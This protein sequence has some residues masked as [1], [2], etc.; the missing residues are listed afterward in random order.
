MSSS[1][2]YACSCGETRHRSKSSQFQPFQ[3]T[4]RARYEEAQLPRTSQK[5]HDNGRLSEVGRDFWRS[6]CPAPLLKQGHL[7]PVVQNCIQT[8]FESL[9]VWRLQ[10]CSEQPV[11]VLGHCHGEKELPDVSVWARCL[12]SCHRTPLRKACPRP[13]YSLTSGFYLHG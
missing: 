10:N 8:T 7:D 11:P 9:Q 2:G 6:S 1:A 4:L 5:L 12:W 13:L 3:Q